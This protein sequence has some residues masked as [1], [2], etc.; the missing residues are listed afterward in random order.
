[1]AT[2]S[3][4]RANKMIRKAFTKAK[5]LDLKPIAVVVYDSGGNLKAFQSQ[6]GASINRFQIASGKTRAAL[7]TGTGSRWANAQAAVRPHFLTGL[8]SVI[9]GGVV[10]VPGG[11]LARDG[12]GNIIAAVGI[13]GDTSDNDEAA[14]VS[15]IEAC[16][17]S[18]DIG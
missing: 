16:G 7:A 5:E 2:L 4:A 18:A 12:K 13:S 10:P 14:A 3:L 6:D 17:L 9:E 15:A 11:V 1:M 8:T